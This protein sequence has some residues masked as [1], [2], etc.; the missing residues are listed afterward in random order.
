MAYFNQQAPGILLEFGNELAGPGQG[1]PY[2]PNGSTYG[3]AMVPIVQCARKLMPHAKL[4]ACG[5]GGGAWNAGLKSYLHIFDAITHHN[6]SPNTED[7]DKLPANAR[8]SFVA[9]YSRA[10]ARRDAENYKSELGSGTPIWLTEFG[11]GLNAPGDCLLPQ[12]TFGAVHGAFH[13][14]R[15]LAAIEQPGSYGVS[16]LHTYMQA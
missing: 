2:F 11:Y 7:V 6:Y 9:G 3:A 14:A 1:L 5:N 10:S 8:V 12:L 13:A 4:A 15:I 16:R